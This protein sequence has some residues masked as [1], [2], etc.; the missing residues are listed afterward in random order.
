MPLDTHLSYTRSAFWWIGFL[1]PALTLQRFFPGVDFL[2]AGLLITLQERRY[3]E[4]I[5][6]LPLMVI[7]QEGMG[8]RA[9]G[10]M[11]LW[12]LAVGAVFLLGRWLFDVEN[13]LY[14]FLFSSCLATCYFAVSFLMSPLYAMPVDVHRLLD[15]SVHL[16]LLLPVF[17]KL[18][19]FT[20]R[21]L[22]EGN[23]E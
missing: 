17:W 14:M 13:F 2:L 3:T 1:F 10:V 9:F 23:A 19:Q 21:W 8:T 5:L 18:A 4:L 22:Y 6:V 12:Y 15:E 7:L 11:L 16:A 20:R